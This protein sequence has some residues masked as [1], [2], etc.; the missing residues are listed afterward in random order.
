VTQLVTYR[1]MAQAWQLSPRTIQR[2]IY[3]DE[4]L[5]IKVP[6]IRRR[7]AHSHRYV[8]LMRVAVAE[9]LLARHL[10]GLGV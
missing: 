3:Q 2:W 10:P 8:T 7:V 9:Q 6:R 4:K 1:E 5:G